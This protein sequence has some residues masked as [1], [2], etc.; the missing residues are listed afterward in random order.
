M[1]YVT[2]DQTE[3]LT[4][5]DKVVV[6]N[7]G[8]VVQIGTPKELFEDPH[9]TFVG[10]FIGSPGMNV[11][12]ARSDDGNALLHGTKS[13]TANGQSATRPACRDWRAPGIRRLPGRGLPHASRRSPMRP[14]HIVVE[15]MW[16]STV[17]CL[18]EEGRAMRRRER[19]SG[20]Q[21]ESD[22]PLPRRL[23]CARE[24]AVMN[25]TV[26]QKAWLFVLPVVVWSRSMRMI[27]ND[28]GGEL[29]GAGNLRQ[30]RVLLGRACD[31]F[32]ETDAVAH[33]STPRL[34]GN[35]SFTGHDPGDRGA[36]GR[37]HRAGDAT[38]GLRGCSVCLVLMAMPLLIPW[39]VVGAMWNIFALPDIGLLGQ[40]AEHT[41]GIRLRL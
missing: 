3:A 10:H 17:K 40:Y 24:G 37:H 18:V 7:V 2:H 33:G 5:A 35:C 11:L 30:Q 16:A 36:A 28:D 12:P 1:I 8:E 14:V 6:M 39:N 38:E 19:P 20:L 23:A 41:L 29:F 25:K 26:N 9:H 22:A 34:A 4:F 27:R 13:A 32:E 21:P 31:W 15:A